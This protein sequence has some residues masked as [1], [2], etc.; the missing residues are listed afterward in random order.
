M[1]ELRLAGADLGLD[2]REGLGRFDL[3]EMRRVFRRDKLIPRSL[4]GEMNKMAPEYSEPEYSMSGSYQ[5]E[6][7]YGL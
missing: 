4:S 2:I 1:G 3:D 7:T 6:V 5:P